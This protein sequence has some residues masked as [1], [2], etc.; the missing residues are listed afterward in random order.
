MSWGI[1]AG[2]AVTAIGG[3]LGSKSSNKASAAQ[4]SAAATQRAWQAADNYNAA[5]GK[6]KQ[7]SQDF[8]AMDQQ[9]TMNLV[10]QGYRAGLMN[11]QKGLAKKQ[12]IQQGFDISQQ[13]AT[14]L[15]AA[16]NNAAAAGASGSS[17]D[18]VINDLKMRS[19]Q[20]QV[21]LRENYATSLENFNSEVEAMRLNNEA[22]IQTPREMII[23]GDL[24]ATQDFTRGLS[25]SNTNPWMSAL[26]AGAGSAAGQYLSQKTSLNLGGSPAAVGSSDASAASSV[27]ASPTS[28]LGSGTYGMGIPQSKSSPL[29]GGWSIW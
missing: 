29:N 18:A 17:S 6:Y 24:A 25:V 11:V 12:A 1:A 23:T 10:R 14:A 27:V 5:T 7:L 20:A 21:N 2:A 3:F 15:G 28:E 22:Q 19:A 8:K 16:S 4:A 26:S 9:N 13:A